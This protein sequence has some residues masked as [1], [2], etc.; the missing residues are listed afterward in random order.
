MICLCEVCC[1]FKCVSWGKVT[2]KTAMLTR[3][4]TS[5]VVYLDSWIFRNSQTC[6]HI[7]RLSW[8]VRS[9]V[10]ARCVQ[11]LVLHDALGWV[12]VNKWR[13]LIKH[14]R[15]ISLTHTLT[16]WSI[17]LSRWVTER[18]RVR[19]RRDKDRT[20]TLLDLVLRV[21]F[22]SWWSQRSNQRLFCCCSC[23]TVAWQIMVPPPHIMFLL[24]MV[25]IVS[26]LVLFP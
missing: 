17:F 13:I 16:F 11:V 25:Y 12:K 21:C 23:C 5:V 15:L 8:P 2:V 10:S 20:G 4:L 26:V 3:P 19:L 14:A 22:G 7:K 1:S 24:L 6:D 9:N 18:E